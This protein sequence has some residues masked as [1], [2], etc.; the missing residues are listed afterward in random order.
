[1]PRRVVLVLLTLAY[2]ALI[3]WATLGSV[4]WHAIGSEARYGVLT[5][6][7]WLDPDTWEV[8][9]RW[10]FRANIAMF[11]PLGLLL[12]M[13]A[14]PRHW[15]WALTGTAA[16][17]VAIEIAQIPLDDRISDPR[18]LVANSVGGAI[19]VAI[20]G[21]GWLGM[22]LV[23]AV[24]RGLRRPQPL[25]TTTAPAPGSVRVPSSGDREFSRTGR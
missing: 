23:R 15:F 11:V 10:E 4:S 17:S 16:V 20:A 22:L 12:A 8:G 24:G 19:G 14:G 21:V 3:A 7:T 2:L 5:P 18:D 6:S 9:S 25:Q 1:M 13:L